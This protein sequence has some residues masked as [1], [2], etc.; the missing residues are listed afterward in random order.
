MV[1]RVQ[2]VSAGSQLRVIFHRV[3]QEP[4]VMLARDG[5][6]AWAHAVS[7]IAARE[8]LQHGDVLSVR[9]SHSES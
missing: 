4:E 7:L 8:E 2:V 1:A 3:G 9:H 5:E 6:Q